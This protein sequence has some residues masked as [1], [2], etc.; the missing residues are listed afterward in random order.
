MLAICDKLVPYHEKAAMTQELSKTI[1]K[2]PNVRLLD[3]FADLGMYVT[4]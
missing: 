2:R 3:Y 1:L 4:C